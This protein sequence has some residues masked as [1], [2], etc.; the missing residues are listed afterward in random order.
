VV[1]APDR[2]PVH[3][4]IVRDLGDHAV[5]VQPVLDQERLQ[6]E[7]D[8]HFFLAPPRAVLRSVPRKRKVY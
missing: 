8:P 5:T 3:T 7:F 1:D 6:A 4:E 2:V